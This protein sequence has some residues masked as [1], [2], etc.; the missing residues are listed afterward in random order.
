M[1]S[2][3]QRGKSFR[4]VF[5]LNAQKFSRSLNTTS[6]RTAEASLARLEDNLRRVNIGT[7]EIPDSVDAASFLLSDGKPIAQSPKPRQTLVTLGKL[8]DR[9]KSQLPEGSMEE[10]TRG[11]LEIHFRHLKR[12]LGSSALLTELTLERLQ[13]YVTKRSK[14]KGRRGRNLSATTIKKELSTLASVWSW[15]SLHGYT[16][17]DLPKKGLVYP[18]TQQAPPFATI[19][20]IE[21]KIEGGRLGKLQRAELWESV[22]L[23]LEEIEQLLSHVQR[24]ARHGFIHP[25]IATAAYTGARRSELMRSQLQ[26]IDLEARLFTIREKKRVRGRLSYRRVPISNK[27]QEI[28]SCWLETHPGGMHSFV[29]EP[30]ICRSTKE[31][32]VPTLLTRD[33]AHHHFKKAIQHSKFSMITGWHVLRHSF[34]SNLASSGVDQRIISE[35]VGHVTPE[36]ESR[37]RHLLPSK[38]QQTM[39]QVFG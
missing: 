5:R 33:E 31:R 13:T 35:W 26:D 12:G 17:G 9:Y 3:E 20:E 29:I 32:D 22:Y 7:L 10:S 34:C 6:R 8:L 1:A 23:T 2:I 24:T 21:R 4:I 19:K 27:L 15:G 36:M 25:M 38:Q 28:L 18:K 16:H 30:D 39:D 37:Y 14:A 11:C